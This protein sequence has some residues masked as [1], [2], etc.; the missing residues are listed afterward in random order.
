MNRS[1]GNVRDSNMEL[2]RIVAMAMIVIGHFLFHGIQGTVIP[3]PLVA[4]R[5]GTEEIAILSL[6][7]LCCAGVDLFMLISGYY[8]IR[9]RWKGIISFWLLCVFYNMVALLVHTGGHS[10]GASDWV[11]ALFI[12]RTGN[13]FFPSYFWVMMCS[14]IVNKA[15]DSFG[16]YTLRAL[17]AIGLALFGVSSW[18]FGNPEANT[19]MPMMVVYFLGGYI[20]RERLFD[21]ISKKM[22]I[23]LFFSWALLG[24]IVAVV[25][26]DCFHKEFG[27]FFQHNSLIVLGMAASL[28]LFFRTLTIRSR[29][30]N[31]WA[32]TVVAALFIQDVIWSQHLYGY[33][34]G[35][36]L[37][38]GLGWGVLGVIAGLTVGVFVVSFLMEWPRKKVA[39]YI[40][41]KG[42]DWIN[43]ICNLEKML[44]NG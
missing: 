11:N 29:F 7:I 24:L 36:Y 15:L 14:P 2:A 12:S 4:P 16:I 41:T 17:A 27:I 37:S 42:A 13:W 33:V 32:S 35:L 1:E 5:L 31:V 9:L 30:I 34:R 3:S 43:K 40:A 20:R 8:G 22:S 26:Y 19:I 10:V 44:D 38:E 25:V 18:R 21:K 23:S 28:L 6:S 39:G